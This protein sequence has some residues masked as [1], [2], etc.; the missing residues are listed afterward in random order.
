MEI[1]EKKSHLYIFYHDT[2]HIQ[3]RIILP[4]AKKR[5]FRNSFFCHNFGCESCNSN[6]HQSI[7]VVTFVIGLTIQASVVSNII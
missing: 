3:N 7:I 5:K 4:L 6:K 2:F 1:Q